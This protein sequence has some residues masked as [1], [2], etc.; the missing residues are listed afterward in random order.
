MLEY[1]LN[2]VSDVINTHP[3]THT[4]L[5]ALSVELQGMQCQVVLSSKYALLASLA[6]MCNTEKLGVAWERGCYGINFSESSSDK[7]VKLPVLM[8]C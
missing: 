8:H 5:V 2:L 1:K 7:A 4:Q 3:H 6:C